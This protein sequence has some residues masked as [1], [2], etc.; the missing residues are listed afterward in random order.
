MVVDHQAEKRIVRSTVGLVEEVAV[1]A[2]ALAMINVGTTTVRQ[3]QVSVI[4]RVGAKAPPMDLKN[5]QRVIDRKDGVTDGIRNG[6][7]E[8]AEGIVVLLQRKVESGLVMVTSED[9]AI[10][11]RREKR[12]SEIKIIKRASTKARRHRRNKAQSVR[13]RLQ[14]PRGITADHCALACQQCIRTNLFLAPF[15]WWL[16]CFM[17]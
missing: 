13:E 14:G 11:N 5:L 7:R 6:T 9:L 1:E 8:V 10:E 17:S 2:P 4:G 3:R 12:K 15:S 16:L